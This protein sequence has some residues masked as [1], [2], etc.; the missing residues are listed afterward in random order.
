MRARSL[1]I[2]RRI[3][4]RILLLRGYRVMLDADLAALYEVDVKVLN[5]AVKRNRVR[6]PADFMF[7]L[8]SGEAASLRSQIVTLDDRRGAHRKYRPYAFTEQGIAMLSGVLRSPRAVLVNIE[9]MRVFVHLREL[10]ESNAELTRRLDGLE[11]K[12]D[13]RFRAVFEAIRGLMAPP[14]RPRR[15]IGFRP[16]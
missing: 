5:Q 3:Q 2:T 14:E 10:L 4:H 16:E 7:Q 15:K 1:A 9:I 6:F 12:S 11:Q 13:R 8:T